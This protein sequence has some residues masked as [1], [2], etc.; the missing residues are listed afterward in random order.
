MANKVLSFLGKLGGFLLDSLKR[1]T[2]TDT[3][4][5]LLG[6]ALELA[7]GFI[8]GVEREN[9]KAVKEGGQKL[10]WH[11][12]FKKAVDQLIDHY[13]AQGKELA[14]HDA[15]AMVANQFVKINEERIAAGKPALASRD[16]SLSLQIDKP[17]ESIKP[18]TESEVIR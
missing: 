11:E 5:E 10:E 4:I 18:P 3:V 1:S 7:G 17:V 12:K 15:A 9:K 13:A 16:N 8:L 14:I 2:G 6:Q